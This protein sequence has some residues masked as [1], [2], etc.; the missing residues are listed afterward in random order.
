LTGVAK[1]PSRIAGMFDAIALRYDFLNHLLSGGIDRW[2][3]RQAVRSLRLTGREVVLDLCT[4]TGDLAI[5]AVGGPSSARRVIGIDFAG[6]MLRVGLAKLRRR[7]LQERIALT[8]GYAMR[9]PAADCS[10]DAVTI[11]FGILNVDDV[12]RACGEMRRVLKPG[13]RLAVL[14]F[15]V[16]TTPVLGGAYLWYLRRVL[17]RVGRLVSGHTGAY[18]YL[19]ASI[20]TF[21]SPDELVDI[22]RLT[23]FVDVR[24]DLLTCGTVVLYTARRG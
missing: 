24:S 18:T 2:W 20:D 15:A 9:I 21:A 10:V 1:S 19:P 16:P 6:G 3:R 23:G 7:A 4:G 8:R 22:L 12:G 13:G 17:P 11:G 14:E 5:Q